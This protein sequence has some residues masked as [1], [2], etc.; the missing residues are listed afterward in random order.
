VADLVKL[1]RRPLTNP[2]RRRFQSHWHQ[3]A[4]ALRKS[5]IISV[6]QTPMTLLEEVENGNGRQIF[7]LS[8]L[9]IAH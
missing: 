3:L 1:L 7:I 4:I 6:A 5:D 8:F 2:K 9:Q